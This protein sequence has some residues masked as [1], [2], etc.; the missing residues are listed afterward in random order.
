M[1]RSKQGQCR[2][3]LRTLANKLIYF[4]KSDSNLCS[5][6]PFHRV[7]SVCII[8]QYEVNF[9]RRAIRSIGFCVEHPMYTLQRDSLYTFALTVSSV[10]SNVLKPPSLCQIK[11]SN[12]N[13]ILILFIKKCD[14]SLMK[15]YSTLF[16]PPFTLMDTAKRKCSL[17][18]YRNVS[19]WE[20][21]VN[22]VYDIMNISVNS[23]KNLLELIAT[24]VNFTFFK[25]KTIFQL[26]CTF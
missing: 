25:W 18:L 1:I 4:G 19:G 2:Y 20:L 11:S 10:K 13:A 22:Y 9:L 6:S 5:F 15:I 23:I 24:G 16:I 17:Y 3:S 21:N 7:S 8:Y 12:T 26:K 14:F